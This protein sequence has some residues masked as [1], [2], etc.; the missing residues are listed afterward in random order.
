MNNEVRVRIAPSPTGFFHVGSARTA[1]Y[2]WLFARHNKGKFILRVEDTDVKRSSK[3]MI[4][5][6][7]DGLTWLGL[8]WDEGPYFQS[9]RLSIYSSFV[10]KLITEGKAYYCFCRS[11][12]LDKEKRAAYENKIDWHY[13][14]RCLNL[15]GAA[16]EEKEHQKIPKV[17][18]FLVPERDVEF[19][20]IVHGQIK[21]EAKNIE[22]FVIMRANGTPTYNLACIVDD[23]EM[24]ISHVIRAVE[25]VA[26]TP[27]QILLYDALGLKKP[28]F[29]HLPLILGE[30][31]KKLSKRHGAVSLMS[32]RDQGI[33][34][35][36]MVNFLALLGWSSGTDKEIMS[37]DEIIESFT[38]DR[39]NSANAVFDIKKL[40]WMNL[41]YIMN[42]TDEELLGHLKPHIINFGFMKSEEID[43]KKDWLLKICEL[44]KPRLHI[45][46]DIK[47]G[48]FFFSDDFEYDQNALNK[49]LNQKTLETIK[50]FLVVSQNIKIFDA[51]SLEQALRDFAAQNN[52]KAKDVIHP[53]RVFITGSEGGPGLFETME[54]LGKEVCERRINKI[55]RDHWRINGG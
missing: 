3:E 45:L 38:L 30:D 20:D 19:N 51:H 48:S 25:H 50:K 11:E 4:Q 2:N 54:L 34:P 5:V 6:I 37:T 44:M 15:S 53:L 28:E 18:R 23:Y 7:L 46:S 43:N 35:E 14:R 21:K 1:L 40:E 12:D 55:L 10:E 36:T 29:A 31:K 47:N 9:E 27:K 17:V 22:D 39:I 49:H 33:L 41:Q 8:N 24:G 16:R 52:L 32:Y 26:N 13:D 42:F